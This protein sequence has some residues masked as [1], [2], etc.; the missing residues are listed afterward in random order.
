MHVYLLFFLSF[1]PFLSFFFFFFR[2]LY[3]RRCALYRSRI[4]VKSHGS[5]ESLR[6]VLGR[7]RRRRRRCPSQ[8]GQERVAAVTR[9][10]TLYANAAT[11]V[12]RGVVSSSLSA[13]WPAA[14]ATNGS[15]S[16][17]VHPR[18]AVAHTRRGRNACTCAPSSS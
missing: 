11:A 12:V 6:S 2:P 14:A 8:T 13:R 10:P 9:A 3:R 18:T 16:R 17:R 5:P 1:S 4:S 7:R 15:V